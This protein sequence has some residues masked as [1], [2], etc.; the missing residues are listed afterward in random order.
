MVNLPEKVDNETFNLSPEVLDYLH[1]DKK[2]VKT[3]NSCYI[4]CYIEPNVNGF[5]LLIANSG[6][7]VNK[8]LN[9]CYHKICKS[10]VSI[11]GFKYLP[12]SIIYLVLG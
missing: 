7:S 10:L 5:F 2:L 4:Y 3:K 9:L 6:H 1:P 8:Y 11:Y 12:S